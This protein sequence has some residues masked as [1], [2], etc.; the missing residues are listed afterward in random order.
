[1]R[2]YLLVA[3]CVL[4][5]SNS[6][7][8]Q[9]QTFEIQSKDELVLTFGSC[10]R[11]NLPQPLWSSISAHN[12]DLFMFLGDNIYG[13]TDNMKVLQKK[14]NR[15]KQNEGYTKL[16]QET[17]VIGVWDD[18]DYGKNDAGKE[19]EFKEESQQLFLDFFDVPKDDPRRKREG[20]YSSHDINW[21]SKTIRVILLDARYFRDSLE[22]INRVYQKNETGTVLG[23]EQW[24]WLENQ[25][26]DD[27]VSLYII[28][29]GIQMIPEDHDYE[30]WANFPKERQ[31]LLDLIQEK[32]PKGVV[33]LSGDRH[34]GE[35]SRIDLEGLDYPLV[36]ITSSGLT[37]V[38]ED[39]EEDNRYRLGELVTKL[40][41]GLIKINETNNGLG[42]DLEIRGNDQELIHFAS[43]NF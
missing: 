33:L 34:I 10:N 2:N 28:A 38:W 13:D 24:N 40:N 43:I 7:K 29:S 37:H 27:A 36:E 5:L 6:I 3:F 30:K 21:N 23:E 14:Y 41:Y 18:H 12:S 31:R 39:A 26:S 1:M 25:L 15:Q 16:R 8:A 42:V 11:E 22:R 20:V 9:D 19:Y 35:I 17:P 4:I 32:Q